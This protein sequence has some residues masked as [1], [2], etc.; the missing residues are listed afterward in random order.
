ME[1]NTIYDK[2]TQG[3][4]PALAKFQDAAFATGR[5]RRDAEPGPRLHESDESLYFCAEGSDADLP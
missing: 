3:V 4:V 1:E 5:K 2:L